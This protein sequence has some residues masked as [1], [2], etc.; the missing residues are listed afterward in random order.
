MKFRI[1][2]VVRIDHGGAWEIIACDYNT[3]FGHAY[4]LRSV[5]TGQIPGGWWPETRLERIR[6]K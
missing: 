6:D 5:E 1:G 2:E 4:K 3:T